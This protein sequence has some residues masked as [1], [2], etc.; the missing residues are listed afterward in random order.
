MK[1]SNIALTAVFMAMQLVVAFGFQQ[2]ETIQPNATEMRKSPLKYQGKPVR[3]AGWLESGRIFGRLY[4]FA[5]END[6]G[7]IEIE[8]PDWIESDI[9][10]RKD[11]LFERL[12]EI[13]TDSPNPCKKDVEVEV[14]GFVKEIK[15]VEKKRDLD[16]DVGIQGTLVVTRVIRI[17]EKY[18][19][20]PVGICAEESYALEIIRSNV[21]EI[22]NNPLKYEGKVVQITGWLDTSCG[23]HGSRGIRDDV[24]NYIRIIEVD[25]SDMAELHAFAQNDSLSE[26]FWD[27]CT[28]VPFCHK[29]TEVE[30]EGF[31]IE[32][33]TIPKWL[34]SDCIRPGVLI[35]TRVIRI[36]EKYRKPP[37]GA[38]VPDTPDEIFGSF[39]PVQFDLPKPKLNIEITPPKMIQQPNEKRN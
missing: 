13:Y 32:N 33:K 31:V 18:R 3:I 23:Q 14:E 7:Y 12:W 38:C 11:D 29:D 26:K 37:E 20:P 28:D 4:W 34:Y 9:F 2:Q 36:E 19:K 16:P 10:A 22:K 17:E 5:I 21:P 35:V 39:P 24:D 8:S 6:D 15:E 30:V 27:I 1:I 25:R